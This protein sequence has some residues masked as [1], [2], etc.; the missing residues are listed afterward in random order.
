METEKKEH[1]PDATV[2]ISYRNENRYQV[3]K[4]KLVRPRNKND[5]KTHWTEYNVDLIAGSMTL[6]KHLWCKESIKSKIP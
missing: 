5:N 1:L 4:E 2:G 6:V 3:W